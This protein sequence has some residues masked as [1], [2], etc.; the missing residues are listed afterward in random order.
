MRHHKICIISAVDEYENILCWISGFGSESLG[1][2]NQFED[3]FEEGSTIIADSKKCI[4]KFSEQHNMV[5]EQIPRGSYT[6]ANSN[7]LE[8]INQIHTEIN[9]LI[10]DK[11]GFSTRHAQGHLDWLIFKKQLRY[12]VE[13]RQ[14]K[15]TAYMK[16]MRSEVPFTNAEIIK[17]PQPID[18]YEAYGEYQYGIFAGVNYNY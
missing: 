10:R 7:S 2:Y 1:K 9:N 14:R 18:L 6:T 8:D 13:L 15:P 16:V 5:F 3:Y 4:R 12:K 17:L 11:H